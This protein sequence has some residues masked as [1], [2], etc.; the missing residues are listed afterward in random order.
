MRTLTKVA[1]LLL[2]VNSWMGFAGRIQAQEKTGMAADPA[3]NTLTASTMD[4]VQMPPVVVTGENDSYYQGKSTSGT[5]TDTPIMENPG[6]VQVVTQNVIEDQV[7]L[8]L[9]DAVQNVSGVMGSNGFFNK[10]EVIIRGYDN[11]DWTYVD[12]FK[13]DEG[14]L[15][16]MPYD[17]GNIA[18]IEIDK[19]PSSALYG[20]TEPGG[21]VNVNTKNP[22]DTPAY[23]LTYN[24]GSFG[25]NQTIVDLTGPLTSDKSLLYRLNFTDE[26]DGSFIQFVRQD[27]I[28]LHPDLEWI[29]DNQNDLKLKLSYISGTNVFPSGFP[30][31][32]DGRPVNVPIGS[33][34]ADPQANQGLDWEYE[35]ETLYTHKFDD[36]LKVDAGYRFHYVNDNTPVFES[37]NG[38]TDASGNLT[39]FVLPGYGFEHYS[40]EA[41]LNW[42]ADINIFGVK[43]NFLVGGD[44]LNEHGGWSLNAGVPSIPQNVFN[45]TY[46]WP[47]TGIDPANDLAS[48]QEQDEFGLNLQ[49]QITVLDNLHATAGLGAYINYQVENYSNA[50]GPFSTNP[51]TADGA[52][53]TPKFGLLWQPVTELSLYGSYSLNYG[54]GQGGTLANGQ[55]A[56]PVSTDQWEFGVKT[57]FDKK[58]SWTASVYQLTENNLTEPDPNFPPNSGIVLLI[59]EQQTQG[60]ETDLTGE[61]FPGMELIASYSYMQSV[62]KNDTNNTP[63]LDGKSLNGTSPNTGSLWATYQV[64]EGFAKGFQF[65]FGGLAHDQGNNWQ[66]FLDAGNH[67]YWANVVTPAYAVLNAMAAYHCTINGTK[68]SFQV[69]V[70]NL[71]NTTYWYPPVYMSGPGEPFNI[72]SSVKLEL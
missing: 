8:D 42:T 50:D 10:D 43:N 18:N 56:P 69:N 44:Y 64:Q 28:Y 15:S 51:E 55:N 32:P 60:F 21:L 35:V 40:H 30:I 27:D 46:S 4:A 45:P 61:L 49:D 63:S 12:G 72:R 24:F 13:Q 11:N 29:P 38:Q 68:A 57:Q 16:G 59:G 7:D 19:G 25:L 65:G 41:Y 6:S 20:Q 39:L 36:H 47:V 22:S 62:I 17:M 2:L 48:R 5:K 23:S 3:S 52:P 54:N 1:L 58:F 33:N 70:N 26:N 67:P 31:G 34:F 53:L 71:T 9:I 66:S 37:L 14:E